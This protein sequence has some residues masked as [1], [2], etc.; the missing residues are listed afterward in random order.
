[1]QC[2]VQWNCWSSMSPHFVL[3]QAVVRRMS[4]PDHSVPRFFLCFLKIALNKKYSGQAVLTPRWLH[5]S[6]GGLTV[7]QW[8]CCTTSSLDFSFN[9]RKWSWGKPQVNQWR[10]WLWSLGL[11]WAHLIVAQIHPPKTLKMPFMGILFN[12]LYQGDKTPK[13]I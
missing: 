10:G 6:L 3:S 4:R 7:S 9:H 8:G 12:M 13:L 2:N 5:Q 11:I 1:M